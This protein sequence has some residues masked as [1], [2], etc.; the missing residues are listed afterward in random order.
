MKSVDDV[1]LILAGANAPYAVIGGHAVNTVLEPRFTADID[2]T[3]TADPAAVARARSALQARD[4]GVETVIA[5]LRAI[6]STP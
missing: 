3:I 5:G 2:V 1:A 6:T 4:W